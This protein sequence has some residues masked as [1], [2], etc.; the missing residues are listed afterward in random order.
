MKILHFDFDDLESPSAGG[1]AVR[2]FEINRR[3]AKLGHQITVVTL[4]Y[5]NA[6]TKTK[7]GVHYERIGIKKAPWSYI[8]YFLSIRSALKKH[9]YDLVVEDNISP[10]T[11]GFSPLFTRKPVISQTQCFFAEESSKKH[12]LP[13]WI[14]QKYG[15]R[16]YKNFIVLTKSMAQ[17]IQKLSPQAHIEIIPN[18]LNEVAQIS[19]HPADS[20]QKTT[21][22]QQHLTHAPHQSTHPQKPYF[23]FLGRIAFYHKGL[24]FLLE[25]M[26]WLQ[27]K[28]SDIQVIVAGDGEDKEKFLQIIK[29]KNLK[30]VIYKGKV[31]GQQKEDLLKNCLALVQPSRFEIF[32]F[33]I[34]EAAAHGKPTIAFKIENLDEIVK[35]QGILVPKFNESA[36]GE[37]M[38]ALATNENLR[39]DLGQK[40]HVWAKNHLW[41]KIVKQ[42]E[43]FYLDVL[44]RT[45]SRS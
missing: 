22:S 21:H 5:E 15:A 45:K 26:E 11:F 20:S 41:D 42:Q 25:S 28:N 23:L 38:L 4:D 18:G 6:Q 30:N 13:F 40:A 10:F 34:L 35:D 12:H 2:T 17:K 37:A 24:D 3:L 27:I 1:Q 7:E 32:P 19:P 44:A 9:D 36:F 29:D 33:T 43:T 8:S 31:Q 39:N 14:F 16:F